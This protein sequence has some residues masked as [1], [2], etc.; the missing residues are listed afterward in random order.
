MPAAFAAATL[1]VIVAVNSVLYASLPEGIKV[2][3]VPSVDTEPLTPPSPP[4]SLKVSVV[5]VEP[6]IYMENVADTIES[7]DTP[8]APLDGLVELT[9]SFSVTPPP[10]PPPEDDDVVKLASLPVDVPTLLFAAMR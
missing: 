1:V 10:P 4:L 7:T 2:A 8:V 9:V 6:F 3:L 5:R